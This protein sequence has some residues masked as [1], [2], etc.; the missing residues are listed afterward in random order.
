ME[1]TALAIT[2][3]A[4]AWDKYG[5]TLTDKASD[6][7]RKLWIAFKWNA[8]AE[9]YR[10]KVQKL[11]GTMQIMGMA[12]PVQLDDIYT[13]VYLLDKPTAI[14]RF[15][16]ERLKQASADPDAPPPNAK[17]I[18]GLTLVNKK[19]NLFILGKPGAGKTTFLKYI[20]IKAAEPVKPVI[21]KVLI[22]FP[23]N[24]GRIPG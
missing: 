4:W 17:R 20:A 11:Y 22:S 5:R 9:K 12:E 23:S 7:L 6:S 14:G 15:D 24:S 1:P 16:I 3:G 8:A 19:K 18:G 2:A 13:E 10:S 21:D